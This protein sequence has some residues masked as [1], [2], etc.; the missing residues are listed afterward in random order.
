M[1]VMSGEGSNSRAETVREADH[2]EEKSTN[3]SN[4]TSK[5]SKYFLT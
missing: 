5:F 3:K 1:L 2:S 4:L